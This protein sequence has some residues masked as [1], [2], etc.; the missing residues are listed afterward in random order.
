MA[1]GQYGELGDE[2]A[3]P[4]QLQLHVGAQLDGVEAKFFEPR[5]FPLGIRPGYPEKSVARP[6]GQRTVQYSQ[7]RFRPFGD[8]SAG[9]GDL[10]IEFRRID[11]SRPEAQLVT[12]AAEAEQFRRVRRRAG[13]PQG[14]PQPRDV[15]VHAAASARRRFAV[16]DTVEQLGDGDAVTGVGSSAGGEY[17]EDGHLARLPQA[18]LDPVQ[19]RSRLAE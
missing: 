7:G 15:G 19:P 9:L 13:C 17:G 18:D 4:A 1:L 14:A 2:F 10:A 16:P 6:P 12:V 11:F 5:A 3:L 8:E